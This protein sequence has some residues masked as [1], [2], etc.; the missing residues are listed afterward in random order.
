MNSYS[1][2]LQ[3]LNQS[4]TISHNHKVLKNLASIAV[5]LLMFTSVLMAQAPGPGFL[6][7]PIEVAS[8]VPS[9][10]DVNP[11]G[12]A[13]VPLGFPGGVLNPGDVLVSKFQQ[14][15]KPAR[16]RH[17]DCPSAATGIALALLYCQPGTTRI[18]NCLGGAAGR[19]G[20]R[21]L[22]SLGGWNLQ[23]PRAMAA[24]W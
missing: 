20:H 24:C 14:L 10:G 19:L 5:L 11:Y 18:V 23:P 17:H 16:Y 15:S 21:W 3:P 7:Y 9:N 4:S 1:V 8:T 12:V 6:P 13:F 2:N 22:L